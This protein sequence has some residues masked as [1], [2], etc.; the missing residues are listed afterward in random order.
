MNSYKG[1][2]SAE[3]QSMTVAQKA[4]K[5]LCLLALS[6]FF[7]KIG[8]ADRKKAT[9]DKASAQHFYQHKLSFFKNGAIS[10]SSVT[11]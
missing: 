6:F 5:A 9:A 2:C 8:A 10:F 11:V 3:L 1:V 7:F 4:Q